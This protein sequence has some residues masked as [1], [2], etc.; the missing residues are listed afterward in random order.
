MT[1]EQYELIC[2]IITNGAPA[3][4][5]EL[6]TALNNLI[7]SFNATQ[8]ELDMLKQEKCTTKS[9]EEK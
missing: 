2:K 9:E 4:S 5:N 3:L 1:Q 7:N 8:K 6:C